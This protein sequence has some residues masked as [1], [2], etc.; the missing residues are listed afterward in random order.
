MRTLVVGEQRAITRGSIGMA[1]MAS[2]VILSNL[3]ERKAS[4]EELRTG[5]RKAT[6]LAAVIT[7]ASMTSAESVLMLRG[8]MP[9]CATKSASLSHEKRSLVATHLKRDGA[10]S[11]C[12]ISSEHVDLNTGVVAAADGSLSLRTRRICTA[13]ERQQI[14]GAIKRRGTHRK[15]QRVLRESCWPR[16]PC[17]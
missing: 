16:R 5:K 6:Y 14:S 3:N 8:T 11:G 4:A 7:M 10:G 2:S 12:V 17:A 15:V 1:S 9:T 13:H